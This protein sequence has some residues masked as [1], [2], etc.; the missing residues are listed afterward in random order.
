[1]QLTLAEWLLF[2][3]DPCPLEDIFQRHLI[4]LDCE[5]LVAKWLKNGSVQLEEVYHI[6]S[7][8]ALEK[9][10]VGNWSRQHGLQW[11]TFGFYKR[12]NNLRGLEFLV[13]V[14]EVRFNSKHYFK[15]VLF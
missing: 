11:K 7:K 14:S 13:G 10:V 4:P 6:S 9:E 12:R 1:V 5:F 2:L 15:K 8:L 3:W